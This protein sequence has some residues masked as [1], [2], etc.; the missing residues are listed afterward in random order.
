MHLMTE[1]IRSARFRLRTR[2]AT[3]ETIRQRDGYESDAYRWATEQVAEAE[4]RW[5]VIRCESIASI[6][7]VIGTLGLLMLGV[8]LIGGIADLG[9]WQGLGPLG[10][11]LLVA[12]VVAGLAEQ[13]ADRHRVNDD[14]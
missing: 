9:L 6:A 3:A 5:R 8:H 12:F 7:A 4:R 1:K 11:A 2:R 14:A 13:L 10:L